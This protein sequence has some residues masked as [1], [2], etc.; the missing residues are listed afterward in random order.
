[1]IDSSL[2]IDAKL[3][4]RPW[5]SLTEYDRHRYNELRI[6]FR[7][8]QKEH[9]RERKS[10]PFVNEIISIL[11]YVD[12]PTPGRD[13]RCI[14][15]GIAAAGGFVCVNTQQLKRLIG[16]CKSSVN[17]GFQQISYDVVRNRAKARDALWAIVPDVRA[18]A[19][20][21]RQWTVRCATDSSPICFYALYVAP[22]LP[23]I[24]PRTSGSQKCRRRC[25]LTSTSS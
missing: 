12:Q 11:A 19:G 10:A 9:L 17:S 6:F 23:P 15:C 7:Q 2:P 5:S 14:V 25:I 22:V 4:L 3:P 8:Q 20:S 13:S 18:D 16:R 24:S 1:M 21:L